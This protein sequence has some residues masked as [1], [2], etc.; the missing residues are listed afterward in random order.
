[1]TKTCRHNSCNNLI[2]NALETAAKQFPGRPTLGR[3]DTEHHKSLGSRHRCADRRADRHQIGQILPSAP[4]IIGYFISLH[5]MLTNERVHLGINTSNVRN[6]R[7]TYHDT[8]AKS[9]ASI[10]PYTLSQTEVM[11]TSSKQLRTHHVIIIA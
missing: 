2:R 4:C 6:Q 8:S 5:H 11:S 3:Q 1:M 7:D 10:Q 9:A